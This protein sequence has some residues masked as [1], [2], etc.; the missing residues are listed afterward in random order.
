MKKEKTI[1]KIAYIVMAMMLAISTVFTGVGTMGVMEAKA[2]EDDQQITELNLNVDWSKLPSL[3]VGT[4]IGDLTSIPYGTV[5]TD[6][7]EVD[8][9]NMELNWAIEL[10][11]EFL[12]KNYISETDY[13]VCSSIYNNLAPVSFLDQEYAIS[14]SDTFY[15]YVY[16]DAE[17]GYKFA[18]NQGENIS[19]IIKSNA[20]GAFALT[21]TD[22]MVVVFLRLGT[23]SEIENNKN[24]GSSSGGNSDQQITELKV[25]V[26]WSKIP[27]LT[28]GTAIGAG[29]TN[30]EEI[31]DGTVTINSS[32]VEDSISYN[33]A[34]QLKPEFVEK[35]YLSQE[36]YDNYS[37]YN[38]LAPMFLLK[39]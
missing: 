32:E 33:W 6:S 15:G 35:N 29:A 8:S 3:T 22:S 7:S 10:K 38:Y 31:P 18:D 39:G 28:V 2:D 26:D 19:G 27:D 5:A 36:Y 30:L 24:N 34:I 20:S 12:E 37:E 16:V 4:K 25:N 11:P 23:P 1:R 14:D 9:D 13:N 17:S 21:Q